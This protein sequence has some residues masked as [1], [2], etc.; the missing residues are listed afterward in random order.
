MKRKGPS[1]WSIA[2]RTARV[3]AYGCKD[4]VWREK[5]MAYANECEAKAH[6]LDTHGITA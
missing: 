5:L 3:R 4:P 6:R 1:L 2:A